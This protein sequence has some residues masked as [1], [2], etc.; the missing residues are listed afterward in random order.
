MLYGLVWD[1]VICNLFFIGLARFAIR[2]V[3]GMSVLKAGGR[4]G[5][6]KAVF[7]LGIMVLTQISRSRFKQSKIALLISQRISKIYGNRKF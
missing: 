2:R 1:I 3:L 7:W 4:E 6:M 5:N